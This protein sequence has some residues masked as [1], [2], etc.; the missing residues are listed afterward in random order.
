MNE[1]QVAVAAILPLLKLI[2]WNVRDDSLWNE[3]VLSNGQV[4]LACLIGQRVVGTIACKKFGLQLRDERFVG[5]ACCYALL[6]VD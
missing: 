1:R 4:D 3:Y 2:G 6:A 5:Q